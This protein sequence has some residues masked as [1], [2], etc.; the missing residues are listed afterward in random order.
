MRNPII[1]YIEANSADL[2]LMSDKI[3]N[4]PEIAFNEYY[5]TDILTK[6]LEENDYLVVKGVGGIETAFKATYQFGE[7]GPSIGLLCE[8]DALKIGHACGHHMQGP[9][10]LLA[11]NA[12][13]KLYHKKPFTLVIYGTPA[14]EGGQ[15]KRIMMEN[16]SFQDI[17]VAL[18]T[19]AASYTTVDIKSLSGSKW[20]AEFKGVAAHESL[21]PEASRSALDAMILAFQGIE[22]LRG[23]V[24]EDVKFM[25]QV[26]NCTDTPNNADAT[27]AKCNIVIR[28]YQDEDLG[29]LE[30]RLEAVLSGA[31]MMTGTKVKTQKLST[32]KGKLPSLSL[33]KI[34]MDHAEQLQAPNR[35]PYRERTGST[36]FGYVTH[37]MPGAVI[38]F[39][40]APENVTTHSY[41]FLDYASGEVAHEGIKLAAKI[42]ALTAIDLIEEEEK[43][44]A[45]KEEFL[46][47]KQN[48]QPES[49]VNII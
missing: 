21:K 47:R 36:D 42:I 14:E 49:A 34:F 43:L 17:E 45:V 13:K 40:V 28:T 11:A 22:F 44:A 8:Y 18:M 20:S 2:C 48:I 26:D 1:E 25:Y 5:A 10:M 38:R 30:E 32:A 3:F 9:V 7:G 41:E 46:R 23:H 6:W 15:G 33:N 16:G 19:H 4:H 31:A 37:I 24:K 29:I 27:I 39:P 12:V 35:I